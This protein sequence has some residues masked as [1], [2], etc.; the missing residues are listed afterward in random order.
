VRLP[1][2]A[3]YRSL[4]P[5]RFARPTG[6]ELVSGLLVV[7]VALGAASVV[8]A[9]LESPAVGMSDASPVYLVP[10]VVAGLR[11]GIWAALGTAIAAFLV[12]DLVFT[13]PR[14]SFTVADP[15]E[16][17]DLLLFLFVA[18]VV[19]RL[20]A[21]GSERAQEAARRA[22]ESTSLFA[23]SRLL[24]TAPDLETAGAGIVERL[25]RDV[26]LERAWI[27]GD[28][29]SGPF[30]IADSSPG[31][32]LP[33][34][35]FSTSLVR[36]PGD[37]PAK[38]V[39]AHEGSGGGRA[40]GPAPSTQLLKVRM[41][42]DDQTF[43]WLRAQRPLDAGLPS[44]EET[45]LLA[46]AADQLALALRREDLRRAATE[47]EIARESDALKSAPLDAVSHDLR[48]PLASIRAAAGTLVDPELPPT[49]ADARAAGTVIE[50]EA[51][52]LDQLVRDVL[53]LSQ[54]EGGG[55]RPELVALDLRDVVEPVVERLRPA[56]GKRDVR[57]TLPD[58]L[59]PVAGDAVLLDAVVSNLVENA[60]HHAPSP[61]AVAISATRNDG[62]VELAVD[63]A[64]PG[65]PADG[66]DRL[67]DKFFRVDRAGEGSRRGMGIGLSVVRGL[68]EAMGGRVAAER[69]SLGGLRV[70]VGIP[71]AAEPP[72]AGPDPPRRRG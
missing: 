18:I 10:V 64:G 21:L 59:P 42:A 23:I 56:L 1:A 45:R 53:D 68:T 13:E 26:G 70:V 16:L 35:P 2:L 71:I 15:R 25:V 55:L 57:V 9:L 39:K 54:I 62:T 33:A 60:A 11:Y 43:G 28:R 51:T 36:T 37:Q 3:D 41:E 72:P 7:A 38:W 58:D 67:F 49:A 40:P 12:Y 5:P 50:L 31:H 63:D 19:G 46:L 24:A 32:P 20:A 17:L 44:R 34:S 65:V 22:A 69:S 29:T 52:R 27:V 30:V 8:V 6:R 4:E 66:L 61:A 47:T 14:F 48:T